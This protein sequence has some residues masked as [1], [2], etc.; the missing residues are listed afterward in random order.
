[1]RAII[2]QPNVKVRITRILFRA[3]LITTGTIILGTGILSDLQG[4]QRRSGTSVQESISGNF[5]LLPDGSRFAFWNDQTTYTRVLYV[6][7]NNP[8]ASDD[9]PG[10]IERPL[11]TISATADGEVGCYGSP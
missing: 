3:I 6:A 8:Q 10:T 5:D 2:L 7:V 11:K 4:Q 9:N 1:M